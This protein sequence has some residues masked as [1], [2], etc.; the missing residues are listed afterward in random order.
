[1]NPPT[2]PVFPLKT[3]DLATSIVMERFGHEEFLFSFSFI[4]FLTL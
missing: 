3:G 1:M 4:Y 2:F